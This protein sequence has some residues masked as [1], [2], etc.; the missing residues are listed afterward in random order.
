MLR[1][2]TLLCALIV[3]AGI[4]AGT[5]ASAPPALASRGEAVYFE[6]STA[7]LNPK[8]REGAISQ[9]STWA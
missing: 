2:P 8:T 4:A 1:K 7:L 5:V 3:C 6:G 9:L